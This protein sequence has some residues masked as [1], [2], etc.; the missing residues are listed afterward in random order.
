M[1]MRQGP[2]F[3]AE[4]G[5]QAVGILAGEAVG[6]R[7]RVLGLQGLPHVRVGNAGEP[8]RGLLGRNGDAVFGQGARLR[9]GRDDF[10]IDQDAVAIEDDQ[11]W[12][13]GEHGISNRGSAP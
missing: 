11:A 7:A 9:A 2:Q 13:R 3:L 10:A 6:Q 1:H 5:L 8:A 12:G 4:R